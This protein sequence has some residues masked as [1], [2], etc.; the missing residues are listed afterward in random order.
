MNDTEVIRRLMLAVERLE[1]AADEQSAQAYEA[2]GAARQ[3]HAAAAGLAAT[4]EAEE[5]R[6]HQAMTRL[7]QDHQSRTELA[8]R[9]A[10]R[11]AWQWLAGIGV[12]LALLV[13]GFVLLLGHAYTRLQEARA[14]ADA[15][16]V[17][18]EVQRAAQQVEI[19]SCGGRPC[20]RLDPDAPVWK[21]RGRAYVLVEGDSD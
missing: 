1:R 16:E 12:G 19:T 3:A 8:L 14:R 15:A 7:F 13:F 2:A 5:A 10:V 20:I 6:F 18:A 9:P 21:S 11:R 17:S 4:R